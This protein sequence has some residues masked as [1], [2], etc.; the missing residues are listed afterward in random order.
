MQ[1]RKTSLLQTMKKT[2][3]NYSDNSPMLGIV[4]WQ[5][6]DGSTMSGR[7][8]DVL[9]GT[10]IVRR[11]DGTVCHVAESDLRPATIGDVRSVCNFF[12]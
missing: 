7:K 2:S 5:L 1:V 11:D 4:A 9:C 12:S 6:L 3:R 10:S 8:L